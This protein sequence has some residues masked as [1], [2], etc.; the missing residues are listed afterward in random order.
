MDERWKNLAEERLKTLESEAKEAS[1][2]SAHLF[3]LVVECE[4]LMWGP[5]ECLAEAERVGIDASDVFQAWAEWQFAISDEP[6]LPEQDEL[7]QDIEPRSWRDH[8]VMRGVVNAHEFP[9]HFE[10]TYSL[11]E[12]DCSRSPVG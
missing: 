8:P 2:A 7:A 9:Y 10:S 1:E 6:G 4:E 12:Q 5:P 11:S 3:D